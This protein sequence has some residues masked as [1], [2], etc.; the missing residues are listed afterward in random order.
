MKI[1]IL[2]ILVSLCNSLPGQ[3][4][5]GKVFDHETN[6]P[7]PF[8]NVVLF[9]TSDSLYID[10]TITDEK[11]NFTLQISDDNYFIKVSYV[12]YQPKL[13]NISDLENVTIRLDPNINSLSE[14]TITAQQPFVKLE[15]G[16]ISTN[17]QNSR[18]GNL[19]TAT[20]VL[21]QLPLV[22]EDNGTF[23]IFGKGSPLI[24]INNRP[25]R[26]LSELENV[27]SNTIKK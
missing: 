20:D 12:G 14:V 13:L 11:G 7:L 19:G 4:L 16:G 18:L 23:K 2:L 15:R 6:E 17:I 3:V 22:T 5:T 8:V 25:I 10:G 24:Y 1:Y 21:G 27:N 9:Q 26:D